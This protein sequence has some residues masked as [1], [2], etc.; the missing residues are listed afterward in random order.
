MTDKSTPVTLSRD[1]Q[2]QIEQCRRTRNPQLDLGR[3]GLT[4]VPEEVFELYWLEELNLSD[5]SYN[6]QRNEWYTPPSAGNANHISILP[7]KFGHLQN[8]KNLIIQGMPQKWDLEDLTPLKSLHSLQNLFISNTSVQDLTPLRF[9]PNLRH[10]RASRTKIKDLS[11]LQYIEQ[12]RY[13]N[14]SYT[15]VQD[16]TPLRHLFEKEGTIYWGQTFAHGDPDEFSVYVEKCPLIT[17]PMEVIRQ[18]NDSI[19]NYFREQETQ[20]TDKLYE[21]KLLLV[22]DGGAGKTSLCRRLTDAQLPLP[23]EEETTKGINIHKYNFQMPDGNN[24]RVNI[25][26]FGGQEIYHATH[27]FFL[28]KR[29]LYILLD[30]T[31]TNNKNVHDEGFNYWLEVVDLLSE[32]SPVLIF[33]NEKGGRSKEIDIAGIKGNFDN[34]K[35]IY[36]GDLRNLDAV[37]E[38]EGAIQ[39]F[40]FNLPHIGSPLP[41]KWIVIREEIERLAQGRPYIS[42]REYFDI[43]SKHLPFDRDKALMLSRYLHDLGVF[44]HFQDEKTLCKTIILQ[45]TWATEAVFR[46]LD[47]EKVKSQQGRFSAEDYQ[48]LW[49]TTHHIDMHLELLALMTKF[50][51]CYQLSDISPEIWLA[52]QLLP[53]SRPTDLHNWEQPGDLILKY[54]YA[55]KPKGLISRLMVRMNRYVNR[56][57]LAWK[58]GVLFKRNNSILWAEEPFGSPE[59]ILR[60]CGPEAKELLTII[61][62]DLDALNK[63]FGRLRDRVTRKIPCVCDTCVSMA[64]PHYFDFDTLKRRQENNVKMSN[65]DISFQDIA[66]SALLDGIF[67][68]TPKHADVG[69]IRQFVM[70]GDLKKALLIAEPFFPKEA[71]QLISTL[72]E[73]EKQFN[74][75]MISHHDR[76]ITI[77]RI[78]AAILDLK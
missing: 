6:F 12:L 38:I 68:S 8:L 18:G 35:E 33:Q 32:H 67:V 36:R 45:N 55:F 74:H 73:T 24:F 78:S 51:L 50:E 69:Q 7:E 47:D 29:S 76:S 3:C 28:T 57:E 14:I 49:A 30:D 65:C 31:R 43:Y 53:A 39:Y 42:Q 13:I 72:I 63:S 9:L 11:P 52:P 46:V 16:L 5:V 70:S 59:I 61:A 62:A 25:W 22:G 44:L 41:K 23:Q 2:R 27:Q 26:D 19:I 4:G 40:T 66:V 54:V 71:A 37:R 56:P 60:A 17:P 10:L 21:A 48:R 64:I 75:G 20:G 77:S 34:V 58:T 15:D 1:A